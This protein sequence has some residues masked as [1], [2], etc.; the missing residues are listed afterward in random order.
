MVRIFLLFQEAHFDEMTLVL[1]FPGWRRSQAKDSSHRLR[2]LVVVGV[3]MV[4]QAHLDH[5]RSWI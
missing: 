2:F 3:Q 4:V 5:M 1:D